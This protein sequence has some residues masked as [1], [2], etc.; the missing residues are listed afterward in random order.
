MFATTVLSQ[1]QRD[2][3]KNPNRPCQ[4]SPTGQNS[5]WIENHWDGGRQIGLEVQRIE[6]PSGYCSLVAMSPRNTQA[7]AL[8]KVGFMQISCRFGLGG[9]RLYVDEGA[10]PA[11]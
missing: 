6:P 2:T 10:V 3:K 8:R 5:S 4:M 9:G 7:A 11:C 1:R